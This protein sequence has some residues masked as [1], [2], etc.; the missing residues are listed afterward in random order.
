MFWIYMRK[1]F[2]MYF[3]RTWTDDSQCISIL[4]INKIGDIGF[5]KITMNLMKNKPIWHIFLISIYNQQLQ[6]IL[7]EW[8]NECN[9][10]RIKTVFLG[11]ILYYNSIFNFYQYYLYCRFRL[12]W[13][14]VFHFLKTFT[15]YKNVFILQWVSD[16][17]GIAVATL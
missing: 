12:K 13:L 1:K 4:K 16:C 7:C 3:N 11:V 10:I 15:H 17:Q 8:Q 14:Y 9:S 5:A 6:Y 2:F